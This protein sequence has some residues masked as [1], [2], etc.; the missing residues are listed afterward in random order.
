[1]PAPVVIRVN[2]LLALKLRR[3]TVPRNGDWTRVVLPLVPPRFALWASPLYLQLCF[4]LCRAFAE[5]W[6]GAARIA[7]S[8]A[9]RAAVP[10]DDRKADVWRVLEGG[11]DCGQVKATS[12]AELRRAVD[13]CRSAGAA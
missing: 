11:A 8:G 5:T 2:Q 13:D 10:H 1:V 6:L 3:C 7:R 4:G 12:L 9:G